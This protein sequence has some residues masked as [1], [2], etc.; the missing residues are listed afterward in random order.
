MRNY[1][2][3]FVI[4]VLLLSGS[5][6]CTRTVTVTKEVPKPVRP[7]PCNVDPF[8][9]MGEVNFEVFYDP[10]FPDNVDKAMAITSAP[11]LATLAAWLEAVADYHASVKSCPY[12]AETVVPDIREH[13]LPMTE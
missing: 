11:H 2:R 8:P 6:A 4:G 9:K 1:L 12:V 10:E 13:L 7:E 5:A 3:L